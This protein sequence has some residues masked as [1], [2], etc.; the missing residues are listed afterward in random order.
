MTAMTAEPTEAA[1]VDGTPDAGSPA[2]EPRRRRRPGRLSL[3][4]AVLGLTFGAMSVTPSL[5][6]RAWY[7]QALRDRPLHRHRLRPR[8]PSSAGPT[9][10]SACPTCR[11][12]PGG[13]PGRCWR[14]SPWSC[15][16]SVAGWAAAS[17]PGSASC[18]AWT[19]RC[20]C[21]GWSGRCSG[22][23]VAALLIGIGRA[24]KWVGRALFRPLGRVLPTRVAWLIAIVVTGV[25][26]WMFFSGFLYGGAIEVADAIFAEQQQRRQAR[27]GQPASSPTGRLARRRSSP[28]RAS[29]ARAAPS[30]PQGPT[31]ADI[32]AVVGD[33]DAVEPVRAFVGLEAAPTAGRAGAARRRGAAH[34]GRLRPQGDRGRRHHRQRLDRRQGGQRARVRDPRR[35]RHRDDA[36]LL[37]A[38]LAVL[39]RRP[40]PRGE[41]RRDADHRPAG[42]ARRAAGRPAPGA[43]RL[44]REPGRVLHRQRLH[45]RRG[46]VDD[47]RRGPAHRA[48]EL[49]PDLAEGRGR[50]RARVAGLAAALRRRR[51]RAGRHDRRATSPTRR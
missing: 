46:H 22:L 31:A 5:V 50:P 38:E 48:A 21:S 20:R 10:P 28:G 13:S 24:I 39:P 40:E 18:S 33:P 49:R 37:P 41:Q 12:A 26:S 2:P 1:P 43:L 35:R 23:L 47:H 8:A 30:S 34:A 4:G 14:C 44:R 42:R 32:S 45:Q 19:P 6:P 25:A 27:G 3:A 7:L 29:A 36:V 9:G 17:S 15:C 16:S 51:P 11:P